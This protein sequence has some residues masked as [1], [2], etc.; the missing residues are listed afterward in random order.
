MKNLFFICLLFVCSN[1]YAQQKK[2]TLNVDKA[3]ENARNLAFSGKRAEALSICKRILKKS[4]GYTEVQVFMGRVLVWSDRYDTARIVL[5]DAIKKDPKSTDAYE[6]ITDLEY[7]DNKPKAAIYY[8]SKGLQQNP[9]NENLQIKKAKAV[10]DT[11]NYAAAINL[12]NNVI[13]INKKNSQ[14]RQL[15]DRYKLLSVK[16]KIGIAYDYDYFDKR[17]TDP[18]H[19]T[20]LWYNHRTKVGSLIFRYN[21]INRFKQ[22]GHQGEIDFY[23]SIGKKMYMYLNAGIADHKAS[24]LPTYRFGASLYRNLP[25]AFEAEIGVRYLDFSTSNTLIYT[26][27]VGKYVGSWWFSLR[28]TI[29]PAAANAY[30]SSF[31][32]LGRHYFATANDYLGFSL[33]YGFSPDDRARESVINTQNASGTTTLKSYRARLS[34][35]RVVLKRNILLFDLGVLQEDFSRGPSQILTGNDYTFS[36]SYSYLF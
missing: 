19:Q 16:N 27:S 2:D 30:S 31:A 29:V 32:L 26:G 14:A 23:P 6:A 18:W 35:Q 25:R 20:A 1:I 17:F 9:N 11:G 8:S 21:N 13:K 15:A 3:F 12:L 5:K 33:G 24:F 7:W 4:P 36:I 34:Y 28:P 10:A 22:T